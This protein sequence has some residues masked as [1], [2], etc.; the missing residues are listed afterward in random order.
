[1]NLVVLM[2]IQSPIVTT[3]VGLGQSTITLKEWG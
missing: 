1:V 2:K 3:L